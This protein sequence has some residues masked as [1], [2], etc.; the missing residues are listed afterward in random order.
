MNV[1]TGAGH[2]WAVWNFCSGTWSTTTFSFS[3]SSSFFV[4]G[5]VPFIFHLPSFI[6]SFIL[7]SSFLCDIFCFSY[8]CFHR[9]TTNWCWWTKF[10]PLWWVWLEQAVPGLFPQMLPLQSPLTRACHPHTIHFCKFESLY[11]ELQ[12]ERGK[13]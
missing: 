5:V 7:F 1:C 13:C 8:T 4:L 10:W 9:G 12:G 6:H 3:F 2:P 11:G